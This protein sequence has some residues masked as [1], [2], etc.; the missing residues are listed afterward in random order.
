MKR[1]EAIVREN[2]DLSSGGACRLFHGRGRSLASWEHVSI[3]YFH[4]VVLV[5]LFEAVQSAWCDQLIDMLQD[6]SGDQGVDCIAVQS[7]FLARAPLQ[8]VYGQLPRKPV[9]REDGLLFGLQLGR[10]QN[11]GF[12]LDMAEARRW[13]RTVAPGR[14]ILNLFAYTCAFSVVA[15]SAGAQQVVN[16]SASSSPEAAVA[17]MRSIERGTEP[18]A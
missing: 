15:R 2:L 3:D 10:N 11:A 18:P 7:R 16:V 4:P 6:C 17:T 13:L 8:V 1:V 12:F 5:T 14:R 9:A